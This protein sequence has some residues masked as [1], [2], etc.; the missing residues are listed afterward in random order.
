MH[1]SDGPTLQQLRYFVAVGEEL[2]FGRAAERLG[3]QQPPLTQQ[4]QRLEAKVGSGLLVRRPRVQLTAAGTVLLR[5]ARR[6]IAQA[7]HGLEATRQAARGEGATLTVGF[8]SSTLPAGVARA[9]HDF[10][11]EM[12]QVELRLRELASAAQS[13]ALRDGTIDVAIAREPAEEAGISCV[14]VVREPFMAVVPPGHRFAKRRRIP[15][16]TLADEA[17]VHFPRVVAPGLFDRIAALCR[18]A[19]F[20]PGVAQ[21]A[22]EWMTIVSLVEAGLG[23]TL[24]PASFQHLRWGRVRYLALSS[25]RERT[26]AVAICSR[27]E[28][29]PPA[30]ERFAQVMRDVARRQKAVGS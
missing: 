2:H 14:E 19:G 12:P 7:D 21:E 6:V 26:T 16:A 25:P 20:V 28:D 23:V 22:R 1:M 17:F 29:S 11:R 4:I 5:H 8:A 24:V 27:T 30:A 10:R 3:I 18:T 9:I 13:A 15:L